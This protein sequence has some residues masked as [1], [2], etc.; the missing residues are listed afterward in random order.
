[1]TAAVATRAHTKRPI[2]RHRRV[3]PAG[4]GACFPVRC[5]VS[6]ASSS[7]A[8]WSPEFCDEG[9]SSGS[10]PLG[11][12][13]SPSDGR[14]VSW[15]EELILWSA[16]RASI[17]IQLGTVLRRMQSQRSVWVRGGRWR[18]TLAHLTLR[19]FGVVRTRLPCLARLFLLGLP[20]MSLNKGR[21]GKHRQ[22]NDYRSGAFCRDSIVYAR[23]PIFQTSFLPP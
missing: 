21:H 17:P 12:I 8:A 16:H 18:E 13:V 20:H 3:L 6:S 2:S 7:S 1:M 5:P 15:E 14:C 22:G 10:W 4:A 11:A 19:L 23:I 9:R